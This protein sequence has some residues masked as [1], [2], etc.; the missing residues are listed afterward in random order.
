MPPKRNNKSYSPVAQSE[1]QSKHPE[2]PGLEWERL[3]G[4][5]RNEHE[6][7]TALCLNLA[8]RLPRPWPG[9]EQG[10]GNTERRSNHP[11]TQ[12]NQSE[13][14]SNPAQKL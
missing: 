5:K 6:K 10:D 13:K 8:P 12:L 14:T 2:R 3:A 4:R 9:T 1:W 11:R 7:D